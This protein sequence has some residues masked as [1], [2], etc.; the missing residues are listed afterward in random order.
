MKLM[1]IE[2]GKPVQLR[3]MRGGYSSIISAI[4]RET[5]MNPATAEAKVRERLPFIADTPS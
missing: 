3:G 2:D 5:Q 4:A 1:V